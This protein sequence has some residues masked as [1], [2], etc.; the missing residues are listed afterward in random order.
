LDEVERL[1]W[2]LKAVEADCKDMI[3]DFERNEGGY[4]YPEGRVKASR[5]ILRIIDKEAPNVRDK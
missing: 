4:D 3:L 1:R 5:Q 2:T